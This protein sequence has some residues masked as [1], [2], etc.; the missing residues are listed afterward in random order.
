MRAVIVGAGR[1]ACGY[2]AQVLADSGYEVVIVGRGETIDRLSRHSGFRLISSDGASTSSRWIPLADAIDHRDAE[3]SA[4]A[5]AASDLVCTAV[6][7]HGLESASAIVA[8]G[9]ARARRPLDVIAFEN[10]EDA[11]RI[12]RGAVE[13]SLGSAAWRH[14]FS[15]AVVDRVVAQRDIPADDRLPVSFTAEPGGKFVV[16]ATTLRGSFD[17]IKGLVAVENYRAYYR[18]KLF[19][20][21][22]GHATAAY[23]GNL[24]GY[25]ALH[26]AVR[27][28]EIHEQVTAAMVEGRAGLKHR[29]GKSV[30]GSRKSIKR[31]V[32]RFENATLGDTVARVGRDVPRKI[33]SQER[34]VGPA[35]L[36]KE[37]GIEPTSLTLAIAA[38][39][40][41]Q[42]ASVS[43]SQARSHVG[44][45][46]GLSPDVG[47]DEPIADQWVSLSQGGQGLMLSLHDQTWA[48]A[49]DTNSKVATT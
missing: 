38:A 41:S 5:I 47:L 23:L 9:L 49:Q 13:R 30:V 35:R 42:G 40:Y 44:V 28:P 10:I 22:A 12:V 20:Y 15:G 26:A 48:W 25:R 1:I 2:A 17:P 27:D 21:S 34:L 6:G 14:G 3:A 16:D 43:P 37:A 24:K 31:I 7:P 8:G 11:G 33:G 29:Y 32:R 39:L 46:T 18:R 19:I 4:Q 45:L 36:A